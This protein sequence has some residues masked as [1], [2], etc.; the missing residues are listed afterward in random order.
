MPPA[1]VREAT[2]NNN[3]EQTM[4]E[5]IHMTVARSMPEDIESNAPAHHR[6]VVTVSARGRSASHTP[7]R[8]PAAAMAE[9]AAK[10]GGG[11]V[12]AGVRIALQRALA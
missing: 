1:R 10:L 8:P 11:N 2:E 3:K 9:R 5:T 4:P 12:S 6:G 7:P